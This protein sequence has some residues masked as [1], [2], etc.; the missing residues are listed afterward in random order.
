MPFSNRFAK[1]NPYYSLGSQSKLAK[2]II[3]HII[4]EGNAATI[5][6]FTSLVEGKGNAG[7]FIDELKERYDIVTFPNLINKKLE[8]M[9][10]RRG[11]KKKY[12]YVRILEGHTDVYIWKKQ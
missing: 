9:L 4:V 12:K 3:G 2:G 10:Q 6:T 5:I 1:G 8:G 11:F 7:R